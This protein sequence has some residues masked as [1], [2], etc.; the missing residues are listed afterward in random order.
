MKSTSIGI[1]KKSFTQGI[2]AAFVFIVPYY[3][4]MSVVRLLNI[5]YVFLFQ[6]ITLGP[7]KNTIAFWDTFW[8]GMHGLYVLTS[9]CLKS[10]HAI[11]IY[12]ITTFC[13]DFYRLT[14]C[15]STTNF[16]E[17]LKLSFVESPKA[18]LFGSRE[19]QDH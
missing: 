9:L 12:A 18:L 15:F 19:V 7:S 6:L 11:A 1:T 2:F 13:V 10:L 4:M 16:D 8:Y 5:I 14:Y 17:G 3:L